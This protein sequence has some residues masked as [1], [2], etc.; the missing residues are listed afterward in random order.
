V[1]ANL[2]KHGITSVLLLLILVK[3]GSLT[4]I[5]YTRTAMHREMSFL[6]TR[7]F[8]LRSATD[9]LIGSETL[10]YILD[11]RATSH[12]TRMDTK[13]I[14]LEV[15]AA[16]AQKEVK[17]ALF[18]S[19]WNKLLTTI[20]SESRDARIIIGPKA[21]NK[22]LDFIEATDLYDKQSAHAFLSSPIFESM[23]GSILYEAIYEFLRRADFI[24][25]FVDKLPVIGPIKSVID[26]EFKKSLD[27]T[28]GGQIKA[29]LATFNKTAVQRMAEFLLSPA[30]R[31]A[32]RKANRKAAENALSRPVSEL[33]T[34]SPRQSELIK[35]ETWDAICAVPDTEVAA[36]VAE[37]IDA[38]D[39]VLRRKIVG[40][41]NITEAI[42]RAPTLQRI[43]GRSVQGFLSDPRSQKVLSMMRQVRREGDDAVEPRQ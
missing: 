42:S 30:N 38:G 21:T 7:V 19:A 16:N 35:Q 9:A 43:I 23:L 22:V 5:L 14:V 41:V 29:F 8:T 10:R 33:F 27:R 3:V 12:D 24:G 28:V 4:T 17:Y 1:R 25:S 32:L 34:L 15:L 20:S 31:A 18:D 40:K 13:A 39:K 36:F 37:V 2:A 26:R 6:R 11:D